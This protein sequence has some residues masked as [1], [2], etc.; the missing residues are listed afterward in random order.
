[1]GSGA[2]RSNKRFQSRENRRV[3]SR[4]EGREIARQRVVVGRFRE[5]PF[6]TSRQQYTSTPNVVGCRLL[7]PE[8]AASV[9]G[10]TSRFGS[11]I[12]LYVGPVSYSSTRPSISRRRNRD[13]QVFKTNANLYSDAFSPVA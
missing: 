7:K 3:S 11:D 6:C 9:M 1:M 8:F 4:A 10:R 5:T 12:S 13:A 2:G